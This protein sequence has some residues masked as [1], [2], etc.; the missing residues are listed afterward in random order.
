M[1]MKAHEHLNL[2]LWLWSNRGIEEE[3]T[4][5]AQVKQTGVDMLSVVPAGLKQICGDG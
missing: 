2:L 4:P 1:T 5:S 3:V